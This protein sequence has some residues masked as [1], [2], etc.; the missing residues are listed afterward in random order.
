MIAVFFTQR[1]NKQ[2]LACQ[3]AFECLT[4]YS[5]PAALSRASPENLSK[6][7]GGIG[8]QNERPPKLIGLAQAYAKDPPRP[9]KVRS[10]KGSCPDSEITHLP[11]IGKQS[12][13]TWWVYWCNRT[14]VVT[15]N[16]TLVEY[17]EHIKKDAGGSRCGPVS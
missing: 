14:D 12:V 2:K 8:L 5:T 13:D 6:F 1:T 16:K 4:A 11:W 10:K 17:M 7:F 3:R 9:G 15:E